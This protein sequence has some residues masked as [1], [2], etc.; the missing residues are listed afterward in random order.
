MDTILKFFDSIDSDAVV[1]K[2]DTRDYT[3]GEIFGAAPVILPRRVQLN[4]T[5][6]Q[7]QNAVHV[8]STK[9]A[10]VF[11]AMTHCVNEENYIEDKSFLEI[12]AEKNAKIAYEKGLLTLDA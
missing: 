8:P 12:P 7:D 10:C 5:H 1:D 9:Y 6:A 4:G 11:Y 2:P 3:F